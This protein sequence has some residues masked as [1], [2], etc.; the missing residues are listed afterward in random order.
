MAGLLAQAGAADAGRRPGDARWPG[1][2]LGAVNGALV[3]GLGL[4]SIVVTLATMVILRE[5]LR[6][7]REGEFVRDLP[8]GFQWFGAGQAAGQWLVVAIALAVFAAFAWGLRQPG[9]GPGGLRHRLRPRG[10]AA[11]RHPAPAGRL[12]RLRR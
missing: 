4:P 5:A 3:A 1:P 9:G 2:A 12:R 7:V 6:Y 8:A 11:G 10:G